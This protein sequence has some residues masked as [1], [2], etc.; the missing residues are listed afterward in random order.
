MVMDHN[1]DLEPWITLCLE[2]RKELLEARGKGGSG[3]G[4]AAEQRITPKVSETPS[5][6]LASWVV[7]TNKNALRE[8]MLEADFEDQMGQLKTLAQRP[9]I[10]WALKL[11]Y[12]SASLD[13][14]FMLL[15][16]L[17][18]GQTKLKLSSRDPEEARFDGKY[19]YYGSDIERNCSESMIFAQ[20][21][22][23]EKHDSGSNS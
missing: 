9:A 10:E 6:P 2:N 19:V 5:S 8:S 3:P 22:A 4:A 12:M 15:Y 1:D 20:T 17:F 13:Q 18:T 11:Y 7:H 16:R 14:K 21:T 23:R